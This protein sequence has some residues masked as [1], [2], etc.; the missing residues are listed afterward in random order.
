MEEKILNPSTIRLMWHRKDC[1]I[2][3]ANW[4]QRNTVVAYYKVFFPVIRGFMEATKLQ[5]TFGIFAVAEEVKIA[6][7]W[8]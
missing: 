4:V 3:D 1:F 8:M 6:E 7:F 2:H 5:I